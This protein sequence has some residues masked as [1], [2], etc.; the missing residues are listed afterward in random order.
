MQGLEPSLPGFVGTTG[1]GQQICATLK[2]GLLT[3]CAC[4]Q[5]FYTAER[6]IE[7]V[8]A[9]LQL[10]CQQAQGGRM[11]EL[12]AAFV[13]PCQ[14]LVNFTGGGQGA[15]LAQI[16]FGIGGVCMLDR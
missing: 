5:Y 15:G 8:M 11:T 10:H 16:K 6:R 1:G 4:A 2:P 9:A 3:R 12:F 13:Q 14:R 7:V